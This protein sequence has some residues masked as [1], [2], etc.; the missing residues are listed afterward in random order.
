[1]WRSGS[2][3]NKQ[4]PNQYGSPQSLSQHR[5]KAGCL[6]GVILV[7]YGQIEGPEP[8]MFPRVLRHFLG[9]GRRE[10]QYLLQ[11]GLCRGNVGTKQQ[12]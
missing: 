6:S 7:G 1:M 4:H 2:H 12:I 9:M 8:T 3:R 5:T 10:R 11:K